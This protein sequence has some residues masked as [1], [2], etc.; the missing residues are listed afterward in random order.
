MIK[1]LTQ[2]V[3]SSL[4]WIV[5][6]GNHPAYSQSAEVPVYAVHELTFQGNTYQAQDAPAAEVDFTTTWRHESGSPTYTLHGFYDGDGKGGMAGNVFKV[7]FCPTK[8][9]QWML[10]EAVSSDAKLNG[11]H[12]GYSVNATASA[13]K[14]FWRVDEQSAGQ[15]WYQRSDSSHAYVV[16]NTLYSF[17]SEYLKGKPTGGNIADDVRK[18]AQYFRKLR[19]AV[20]G[21]IFPHPTEKPF[22]NDQGK[23]TDDGNYAHRPNP[24]WFHQRV[25]LAVQTAYEQDL[26]ADMILNGPDSEDARSALL[27]A[28]NGG[29]PAPYLKYIAARYGSYPNVWLCLSNEYDIRKPNFTP[30]EIRKFGFTMQKFLPYDNPLSV[31]ANQGNWSENLNSTIAWNDHIII[32]NKIKK[33]PSAADYMLLNYWIGGGNKPIVNDELAYQGEGDGWSEADVIEA[34]LGAFLGGGYG[35]SGH[36]SGYKLGHYFAGNFSAKEHTAA[37]NLQWLCQKIDEHISFWKMQPE[38]Y[39]Y[40]R[41]GSSSIFRNIRPEFRAMAWEKQECVLG[42]NQAQQ[43]IRAE[44]PEGKWQV[45]MFDVM[46]KQE[47]ELAKEANG[48]FTF[49]APDSRAVMFYFKKVK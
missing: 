1:H 21:D 40:T 41:D 44:L 4:V 42:T 5:L 49:D 8:P 18:S 29:D 33:L 25:D 48:E 30:E 13:H 34:H 39:T 47:K 26:I 11:Q 15:R 22:L 28:A 45:K 9:G 19:F 35:S 14:G 24:A 31:H 38:Y 23:P 2:I 17:L 3:L 43:A 6:T 20:T 10:Q 27:A 32:Q 37:D 12:K 16:G 46:A 36:K 7:R